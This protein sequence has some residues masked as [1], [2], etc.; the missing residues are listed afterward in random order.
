[1]ALAK[2][3]SV[4]VLNFAMAKYHAYLVINGKRI[5]HGF[6][7]FLYL[8]SVYF[9]WPN[10]I[11]F[12]DSLFIRK[13]F[14]DAFFNYFRGYAFFHVSTKTTSLIDKWHY[15]IFGK[16]SELYQTT[17]FVIFLIL[18]CLLMIKY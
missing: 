2:I 11:F 18:S 1:M 4:I 13:F 15:K 6:W 5:Y 12:I 16:N 10:W 8:I 14:F 9:I 7:G 17:Y 3:F